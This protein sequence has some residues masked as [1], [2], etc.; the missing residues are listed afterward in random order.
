MGKARLVH[1]ALKKPLQASE[2]SALI[3]AQRCPRG[4]GK[5]PYC[6][7]GHESALVTDKKDAG[8]QKIDQFHEI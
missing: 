2:K 7:F 6:I 5:N 1:T 3:S 4:L 8:K